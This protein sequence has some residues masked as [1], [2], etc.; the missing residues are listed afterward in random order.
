MLP[1]L[2]R[3][4]WS[5]VEGTLHR[6]HDVHCPVCMERFGYFDQVVLSCSHAFHESCLLAFERHMSN[7]ASPVCPICRQDYSKKKTF[8]GYEEW[9]LTSIVKYA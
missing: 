1:P 5:R 7:R 3:D 4:E 2:S 8:C 9:K 6:R